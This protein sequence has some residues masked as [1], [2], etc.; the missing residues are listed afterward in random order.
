M[1]IT[2]FGRTRRS[3]SGWPRT[4]STTTTTPTCPRGRWIVGTLLS[5][6]VSRYREA[7][8]LFSE[9]RRD[10]EKKA[11]L[12]VSNRRIRFWRLT[13]RLQV[14]HVDRDSNLDLCAFERTYARLGLGGDF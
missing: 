3:S 11:Q 14:G 2:R 5:G 1:T 4:S 9:T 12:D 6:A 7:D 13:P 10:V 8:P